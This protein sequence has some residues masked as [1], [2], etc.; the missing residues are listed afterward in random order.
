MGAQFGGAAPPRSFAA[1]RGGPTPHTSKKLMMGASAAASSFGG[2]GAG[3][4]VPE[5]EACFSFGASAPQ[6]SL[7]PQSAR[8]G[9]HGGEGGGNK[10]AASNSTDQVRSSTVPPNLAKHPHLQVAGWEEV[11]SCQSADG[12]FPPSPTLTALLHLANNTVEWNTCLVVAWLEERRSTYK[13]GWGLVTEK[14]LKWLNAGGH[15]P[16]LLDAAKM[17]VRAERCS[18]GHP[19]TQTARQAGEL[20]HCDAVGGCAHAAKQ[21]GDH[22][23]VASWRCSEDMRVK[24]GGGCNYDICG[25]CRMSG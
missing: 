9:F 22:P 13:E 12:S 1:Q 17:V 8:G 4:A 6:S 25:A 16:A 10:M 18:Q 14:A 19:L 7:S 5:A 15:L 24:P 20:W 2:F 3:A 21:D 11:T 23:G